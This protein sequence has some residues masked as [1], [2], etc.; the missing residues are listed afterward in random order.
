MGMLTD[1]KINELR[2][3]AEEILRG[4]SQNLDE[5]IVQNMRDLIYEVQSSQYELELQNEELTRTRNIL[6]ITLDKYTRLYDYAPNGYLT[7]NKDC[8]IMEANN[9][10]LDLFK[11]NKVSIGYKSLL[12]FIDESNRQYFL[13]YFKVVLSSKEK[14]SIDILLAPELGKDLYIRIDSIAFEDIQNHSTQVHC[15]ITDISRQK[16]TELELMQ[17]QTYLN[18]VINALPDPLFVKNSRH[19][20]V[21]LNDAY[22]RFIGKPEYEL[23]GKSDWDFFE[24]NDTQSFLESDKTVLNEGVEVNFESKYVRS[25]GEE[26]IISVKKAPFMFGEE[27]MVVGIIRDIT[28]L[29]EMQKQLE[30]NSTHLSELVEE[31]TIELQKTNNDLQ[32]EISERKEIE[33]ELFAS[34]KEYRSIFENIIDVYYRL[35]TDGNFVLISPSGLKLLGYDT[36]ELINGKSI[37]DHMIPSLDKRNNLIA[38]LTQFGTVLNFPMEIIDN[39]GRLIHAETN[40]HLIEDFASGKKYIE[41]ILRDVTDNVMIRRN[42]EKERSL[43]RSLINSIPDLIFIKDDHFKYLTCNDAFCTYTGK[44]ISDISGRDDFEIFPHMDNEKVRNTDIEILSNGKSVRFEE[45]KKYPNGNIVTFDTLKTPFT[46]SVGNILGILGVSRDI[47]ESKRIA[48]ELANE[49]K[50]FKAIADISTTL[51]DNHN[52]KQVM[53][54]VL[55]ILAEATEVDRVY[56]FEK[57][58]NPDNRRI[59]LNQLYEWAGLDV[60]PQIENPELKHFD[61]ENSLPTIYSNI[62][63]KIPVSCSVED[64]VENEKAFLKSHDIKSVLI[65]PVIVKE[66]LWGIIGFD[67]TRY[68]R[69]WHAKEISILFVAANAIGSAIERAEDL[70]MI[71]S[72]SNDAVAANQAKS[73]FLANMS[74]EIRTPMNAILGFAELLKEQFDENPKYKNYIDGISLSGKNLLE[75]IND[76]LDLSKIE[77]GKMDIKYEAVNPTNVINEIKQIF[78]LKA[79]AKGLDLTVSIDPTV[80]SSLLLDET[81][82][83]QILFNLVGNAVKFTDRGKVDIALYPSN[84]DAE[85]SLVDLI[86]EV[87]DTG[88]GIPTSQQELIFEAFRQQEGQSNR[89]YGGTGLGLTITRRLVKMMDGELLLSS[90]PGKGSKFKVVLLGVRVAAG[91]QKNSKEL[92]GATLNKRFNFA[93][94]NILLVEDVETNRQIVQ[95]FLSSFPFTIVEAHNGHA[96]LEVLQT[97]KPDVILMDL[98]MP[99]MDGYETIHILKN[100]PNLMRIPVIALTASAL[101]EQVSEIVQIFDGYLRKPVTKLQLISELANYLEH[102]STE[103][104]QIELTA[105]APTTEEMIKEAG[106]SKVVS[107]EFWNSIE[108]ELMPQFENAKKND[109]YK[110]NSR[111][112]KEFAP[113]SKAATTSQYLLIMLMN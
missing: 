5:S 51:L 43:L 15:A 44:S 64:L 76:I 59:L 61:F 23:L 72:A 35:D 13:D 42:L 110:Q 3:K 96:A 80:P 92:S 27:A 68:E 111:F 69:N 74:H 20:W 34:E 91:D 106:S 6:E 7:L 104:P 73:E 60:T 83:R 98:H 2:T 56:L 78:S 93:P 12:T 55:S 88:I 17:A 28:K 103:R 100:D 37:V 63:K 70:E 66:K 62:I 52:Y 113:I 47:T 107:A 38:N 65:I 82:I 95:Y 4:A 33:K 67:S 40:A 49:E 105:A 41:G 39:H 90:D 79:Q 109:V 53:P 81:R 45:D 21:L 30:A 1:D 9:E 54:N 19:E 84:P 89:K 14:I 75:L 85:G 18:N 29:K 99:I 48:Q 10:G 32:V 46:D 26:K 22:S 77:A 71:K 86:I 25:N 57:S 101:K 16:A 102:T 36:P 58:I 11:E 112:C 108:T 24:N 97:F 87:S 31:R 8:L 94:A 50:V